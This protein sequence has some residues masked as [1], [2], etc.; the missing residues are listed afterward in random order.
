MR[1]VADIPDEFRKGATDGENI[2]RLASGVQQ[3]LSASHGST[4]D[5]AGLRLVQAGFLFR[6]SEIAR[7]MA[8]SSVELQAQLRETSQLIE[9]AGGV[10]AA[11]ALAASIDLSAA[12]LRRLYLGPINPSDPSREADLH[13]FPNET[14]LPDNARNWLQDTRDSPQWEVL[15]GVRDHFVHRHFPIHVTVMLGSGRGPAQRL[16]IGGQRHSIETFL[17]DSR[18]FVID[19]LVTVG[20]VMHEG[21]KSG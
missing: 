13:D 4:G 9:F 11:T 16:D 21:A 19:R 17:D 5:S 2:A 15:K 10:L 1:T 3:A 6:S 18:F 12:A 20:L 8:R 7:E 14:D